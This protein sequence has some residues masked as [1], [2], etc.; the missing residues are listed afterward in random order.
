VCLYNKLVTANRSV[1]C[2]PP[3]RKKFVRLEKIVQEQAESQRAANQE[4]DRLNETVNS[5][6]ADF[7][8]HAESLGETISTET[9]V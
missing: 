5:L 8:T 1:R 9:Y 2:R 7:R 6:R 4:K 3:A